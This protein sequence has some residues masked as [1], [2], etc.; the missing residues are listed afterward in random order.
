MSSDS[1]QS[2]GGQSKP[3]LGIHLKCCN[4]YV[5]AYVN[6]AQD[7]YVANCPRC[8]VPVRVNITK[9]GGSSSRFFEAN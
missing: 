9:E 7:A 3:Y 2:S 5:R 6:A 8:A 4:V 1:S